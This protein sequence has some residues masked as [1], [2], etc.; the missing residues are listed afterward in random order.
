MMSVFVIVVRLGFWAIA[1]LWVVKTVAAARGLPKIPDLLLPQ[2]DRM[3]EGEPWLTVIVPARD[4]AAHVRGCLESLLAQDYRHLH[5]IAVDDRSTDATGALMDEI[6]ATQPERITVMH[7]VELPAGWLGKTHAMAVAARESAVLLQPDFLLF[8]DADV[9]FRSDALRRTLVQ[10]VATKAD[11]IVTLP[12]AL[13]RRWDE[14]VMLGFF[15]IFGLWVARPWR[16]EDPKATRDAVGG[17][18]LQYASKVFLS[19]DR[20]I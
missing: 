2:F 9:V 19:G 14:G 1:I 11:H 5:V 15:Q 13:V 17:G 8:T 7:I 16:V 10:A 4:E 6:A 3:P 20:R 12:T 18:C